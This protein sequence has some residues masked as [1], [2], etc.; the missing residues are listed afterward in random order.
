M[1]ALASRLRARHQPL[2]LASGWWRTSWPTLSAE[3]LS[4]LACLGLNEARQLPDGSIA[5]RPSSDFL[6]GS[7]APQIISEGVGHLR[8]AMLAY[9]TPPQ[10]P[11]EWMMVLNLTP[12]SFSDGGELDNVDAITTRAEVAIAEGAAWLDLGAESTRPGAN[13]IADEI[14]LNRLLPA[15]EALLPLGKP[16]SID[17]RSAAVAHACLSAGARMI[18]DVSGLKDP[19]MAEVCASHEGTWLTLMHMRGAPANMR[20][21][22]NYHFLLG[23]IADELAPRAADALDAGVPKERLLLDPGIGFAKTSEQS[24]ALLASVGGLRALGLELLVGPSR[25]S[26]QADLLPERSTE[27]RDCG[28][29]GAASSCIHQGVTTLR[30]HSGKFWDAARVAA[31]IAAQAPSALP[32]GAPIVDAD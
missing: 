26:F 23:E 4:E 3:Q 15:I 19:N 18:N 25:K 31:G 24:C 22:C 28:T 32:P 8:Q 10:R 30:L 11:V 12:D 9:V 27:E 17:T 1:R 5:L 21:H 13:P 7:G 6:N 2:P 29:A 16:L 14:Q 20:T